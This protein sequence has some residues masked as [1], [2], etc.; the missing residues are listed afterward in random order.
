MADNHKALVERV[1]NEI[2]RY[3]EG[4]IPEYRNVTDWL[5]A[6][7]RSDP[8]ALAALPNT[9]VASEVMEP[10]GE[11]ISALSMALAKAGW[12]PH[13]ECIR[14]MLIACNVRAALSQQE[15]G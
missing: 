4:L 10:N 2:E 8:G 9:G 5:A 7:F 6:H 3:G 1:A 13:P 11:N 12:Y 14:A 15:N